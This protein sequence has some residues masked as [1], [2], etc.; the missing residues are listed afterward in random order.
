MSA[1]N[2]GEVDP[3]L[4]GQDRPLQPGSSHD[5]NNEKTVQPAPD[6]QPIPQN[7]ERPHPNDTNEKQDSPIARRSTLKEKFKEQKKKVKAIAK[8]PG[9]YDA[10]PIPDAPPGFTVKF[11]FHKAENLPVADI[12]T[13]TS[14]PYISATLTTSLPK[15]HKEDPD[16]VYRTRTIRKSLEPQWEQEWIVA[17]VPASGFKLKCRLYDEDWPDHDD[18]LGHVSIQVYH[19]GEEWAGFQAPNNEFEVKKRSGSKRA[20]ILKACESAFIK[21]KSMTPKLFVS[22]IVLGKSDPPHGQMYTVGP[23]YYFKHFSP[24]IGRMIGAKVSNDEDDGLSRHDADGA[25]STPHSN[26][27]Q[28]EKK[29][30]KYDFQA[31]EFQLAGPVPP[32]MYHRYVEF[33]PIIGL[34]FRGRGLRGKI[35]NKALHHQ[36]RR[37]Y[38][39]DRHTLWGTFDACTEDAA[40]QFLKMAHYGEGGQIFTYIIT[41]DGMMRW[42]ATGKEIG[43]DLLSKHTL[44]SDAA[45]YIACSGEFFIRRL[46]RP[47]S[48]DDDEVEEHAP[49]KLP[50]GKPEDYQLVIDNDS[51]TYRPDKSVLPDLHNLLE[52]NLPGLNVVTLACD[53]PEDQRLKKEQTKLKKEGRIIMVM[54]RSPSHA[55]FSSSD[56][57]DLDEM[58]RA[59]EAGRKSKKE[60]AYAF[61]EDPRRMIPQADEVV[62]G[63]SG[64]AAATHAT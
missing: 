2:E 16:L 22:V 18:R 13:G 55:S 9:G 10:T 60:K 8:P 58:E 61:L 31:N 21:D 1:T 15:R 53:D 41:L 44:H 20:Y 48:T 27:K 46:K 37:I 5:V 42:T 19:V 34:L 45:V 24:M 64:S 40:T 6:N 30:Q 33:R 35:L 3:A 36:H 14:D 59:G 51:G 38:N 26:G 62:G 25:A 32:K 17:N 52:R 28:P 57:S 54:N 43:L 39:F 50:P 7:D 63:P 29:A 12:S 49:G 4:R 47:E 23:S 56:I 11:V